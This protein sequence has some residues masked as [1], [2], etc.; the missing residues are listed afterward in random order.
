MDISKRASARLEELQIQLSVLQRQ[1]PSKDRALCDTLR[2][3]SFEET[4]I[5]NVIKQL[6]TDSNLMKMLSLGHVLVDNTWRNLSTELIAVRVT[7]R[8]YPIRLSYE[9]TSVRSDILAELAVMQSETNASTQNFLFVIETM[10]ESLRGSGT[11][12]NAFLAKLHEAG[13]LM[14]GLGLSV[15][16]LVL[17]IV[18]LL[19]SALTCGCFPDAEKYTS[20][21]LI[22]AAILISFTSI[23]LVFFTIFT[24]LLGGHAEVFICRPLFDY[25]NYFVLER[26]MNRQG[27]IYVNHDVTLNYSVPV[28]LK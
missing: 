7:F 8:N 28:I 20:I 15:S 26:M 14:W 4:S 21:T 27:L 11:V 17:L 1:C 18:L 10:I 3:K 24:M 6:Q 12:I 22:V 5:I 16:L 2:M 9:T 25:P 19:L 13:N 23:G